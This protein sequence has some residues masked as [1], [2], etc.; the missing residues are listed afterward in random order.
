VAAV[1]QLCSDGEL[2]MHGDQAAEQLRR[3]GDQ[4][5]EDFGTSIILHSGSGRL[6]PA[7]TGLRGRHLRSADVERGPTV[8]AVAGAQFVVTADFNDDG[9]ADWR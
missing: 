6:V 9:I 3:W 4:F 7:A 2:V 5:H 1:E 8:T